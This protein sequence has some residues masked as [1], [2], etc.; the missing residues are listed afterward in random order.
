MNCDEAALLRSKLEDGLLSASAEEDLDRHL[1]EC[2]HCA[3]EQRE[4]ARIFGELAAALRTPSER[5]VSLEVSILKAAEEIT[6]NR[7]GSWRWLGLAAAG[8]V[9]SVVGVYSYQTWLSPESEANPMVV[10]EVERVRTDRISEPD[11]L[12]VERL[13]RH[14]RKDFRHRVGDYDV[15]LLGDTYQEKISPIPVSD[16]R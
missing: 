4:E 3:V 6:A 16:W 11:R 12:P 13:I 1:K 9:V 10:L 7:G 8:F 5:L 14:R 15:R 2:S